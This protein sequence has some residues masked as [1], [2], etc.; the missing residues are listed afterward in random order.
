M[1]LREMNS[2]LYLRPFDPGPLVCTSPGRGDS[3]GHVGE[4]KHSKRPFRSWVIAIYM[5]IPV[6]QAKRENNLF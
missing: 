3:G 5:R 2:M 6:I 4:H 1:F